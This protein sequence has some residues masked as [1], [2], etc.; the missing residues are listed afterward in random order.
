MGDRCVA[1]VDGDP[2]VRDSLATLMELNGHEVAT[3]STARAF[4]RAMD[5]KHIDCIICEAD[6]PDSTGVEL[7]RSVAE[8]LPHIR[9]ALLVS[10]Q[11]APTVSK[12]KRAGIH[13]IFSKPLVHRKLLRFVA[14]G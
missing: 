11:E 8:T 10:R 3:Y 1:V 9:F 4:L 12:A 13:N 14:G 7:Y 6:L 2:A 5:G